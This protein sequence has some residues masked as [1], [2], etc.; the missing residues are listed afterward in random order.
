MK[1]ILANKYFYPR[2]GDCIHAMGL[3]TLLESKGHEVAVFSMQ[4]PENIEDPFDSFWP[5]Q[6]EYGKKL[7]SNLKES[8][9]RPFGSSEI[10]KSWKALIDHFKPDIVHLHNIHTQLSPLITEE[11]WKK[12]IPVFWTL[13]DFKLACPAYSMLRDGKPCDLCIID[14]KNVIKH[15]C[16]KNKLGGSLIAYLEALKWNRSKLE[17]FTTQFIAPS[18]FLKNMMVRAGFDESKLTHINNFTETGKFNPVAEKESYY[19]YVGRLSAEKGIITLLETASG[20]T[21]FKL[22]IFGDG[23]L[24]QT[25]ENE[26]NHSHI[27][28]MGHQSWG[29]VE[30]GIGK[31]KFLVLPSECY[32]NN[33]L[34]IIESLTLGTPVLGAEI[35]GIPELVTP[36][37]NGMLFRAGD[38]KSL[39]AKI[40]EMMA[41]ENW[42][43]AKISEKAKSRFNPGR[44]YR[45]IID[46]YA[47]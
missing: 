46:L 41:S 12:G 17:K 39:E 8:I 21:G 38:K 25:L 36:G 13:H 7:N 31:A 26:F 40:R 27:E 34:S 23:P 11:A 19:A 9:V 10:K 1:I 6:V 44:Y 43:Y 28:F 22:K 2:G 18:V 15:K 30:K 37:E 32:E 20:L 29:E 47:Q 3:K 24:R 35:G 16:I 5:S 42:D 14:K 33:P 45:K 4:Y